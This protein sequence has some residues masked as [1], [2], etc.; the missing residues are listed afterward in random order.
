[1]QQTTKLYTDNSTS[2]VS[3]LLGKQSL[4]S[5]NARRAKRTNIDG[6]EASS[7]NENQCCVCF[8][9]YEEGD[10]WVQCTC[11]RWLHEDCI[12]DVIEDINGFPRMCPYCLS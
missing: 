7:N 1:M 2:G 11:K 10:K 3:S 8:A 9:E 4:V 12:I 6:T 5:N